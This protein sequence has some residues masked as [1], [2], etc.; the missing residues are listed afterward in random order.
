MLVRRHPTLRPG[1]TT[2]EMAVVAP[3]FIL[4][5]MGLLVVG[6]GVFR[7]NQVSY[8][9]REGSRH[10]SVR[11]TDYQREENLPAATE[12]TIAQWVKEKGAGL[13]RD[14]L[15]TTVIWDK[16]NAPRQ[17]D[18]TNPDRVLINYVEVK[19]S[20]QWVPETI[21]TGPIMLSSTSRIP[22]SH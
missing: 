16:S 20:Y 17:P 2:V 13:N 21:L 12:A 19:V 10:A 18:Q 4:F 1:A 22:M 3:L 15:T 11:G 8:L 7:Y 5:V 9:A 6:L 14:L